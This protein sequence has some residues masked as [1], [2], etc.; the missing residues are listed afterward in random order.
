MTTYLFQLMTSPIS[1]LAPLL[2]KQV[3]QRRAAY[4]QTKQ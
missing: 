1:T 3:H 2:Y 4:R